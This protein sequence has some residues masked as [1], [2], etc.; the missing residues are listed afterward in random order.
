[1][2]NTPPKSTLTGRINIGKDTESKLIQA[3]IDSFEKLESLGSEQA[4]LRL[5][6][7][8]PGACLNL[9]YGLEGAIEGIKWHDLSTEKKQELLCFFKM[10]NPLTAKDAK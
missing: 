9:L 8:D 6:A 10:V 7:F 3:G 1:M 4:F 2:K 5:Q